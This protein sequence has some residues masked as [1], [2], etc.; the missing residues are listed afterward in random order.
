MSDT[1]Q[2]DIL[3][4]SC[5]T[6]DGPVYLSRIIDSEGNRV[7]A[8]Q[9]WNGHYKTL[10]IDH[11]DVHREEKLTREQVEKIIP[12]LGFVRLNDEKDGD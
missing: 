10:E 12:F 3:T 8:L 5:A 2:F 7:N 9:C 1:I 6:C 4:G 11:T